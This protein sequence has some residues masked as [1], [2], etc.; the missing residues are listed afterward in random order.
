VD[1]ELATGVPMER[2]ERCLLRGKSTIS[3]LTPL[4]G[5]AKLQKWLQKLVGRKIR[6]GMRKLQNTVNLLADKQHNP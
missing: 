1:V 6:H 5:A 3:G 2:W 4:R